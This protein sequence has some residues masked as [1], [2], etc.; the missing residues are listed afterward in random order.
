MSRV[1]TEPGKVLE[2][3]YR[4]QRP[5][6]L[7]SNHFQI[8]VSDDW[9]CHVGCTRVV[10]FSFNFIRDPHILGLREN[11]DSCFCNCKIICFSIIIYLN[12]LKYSQIHRTI[13]I[14]QRA[15]LCPLRSSPRYFSS[16]HICLRIF[17]R[18]HFFLCHIRVS[19]S[20]DNR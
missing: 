19:C 15:P 20:H 5:F 18:F 6:G 7:T 17:S 12:C 2:A 10:E 8:L 11:E 9:N 1:F 14:V 4:V 3:W 13:V 16:W